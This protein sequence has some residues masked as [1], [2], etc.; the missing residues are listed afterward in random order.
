MGKFQQKYE[1]TESTLPKTPEQ[2][3]WVS[4]LS[5]AAHDAI[6]SS[7]WREA[8][9]AIT[10]FKDKKSDFKK[11]C[12]FAGFNSD[13]VHWKMTDPIAKRESNMEW[14]RTGNRYYVKDNVGLPRGG[15]VYHSHN[16]IGKKRGPYN[17]KKKKGKVGRPRK[18]NPWFVKIGKLG[19]RPK[20]Y[21]HV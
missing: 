3:L 15:K 2:E 5:K 11:V 18:K 20:M 21:N 12:T 8:R 4:V 1:K 6:Y 16:R 14:V 9:Y 13:Y 19:G 17:V 10:W 7:D